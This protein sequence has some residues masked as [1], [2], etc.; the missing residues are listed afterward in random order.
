M[1]GMR[2]T[3]VLVNGLTVRG[4]M[5]L[6][7][8]GFLASQMYKDDLEGLGFYRDWTPHRCGPHS[9]DLDVDIRRCIEGGMLGEAADT[10][11][12]GQVCYKYEITPRGALL[13]R[14]MP[15]DHED[16]IRILHETFAA[17]NKKTWPDFLR[18]VQNCYPEY[19]VGV[20]VNGNLPDPAVDYDV[21]EGTDPG[22]ERA[23]DDIKS[24]KYVGKEYTVEYL[25]HILKV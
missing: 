12:G 21:E 23:I 8:H 5:R 4:R 9:R 22:I 7:L 24:G 3:A 20:H 25:Q 19:V 13:L 17:F 1:E 11:P 16:A 10:A 15:K 2:R 14:N 18:H 6:H